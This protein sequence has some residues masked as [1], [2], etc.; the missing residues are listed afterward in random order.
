M[1]HFV[2]CA[3]FGGT[4]LPFTVPIIETGL[5]V[6]DLATHIRDIFTI[7]QHTDVILCDPEEGR[8]YK[9]RF[10]VNPGAGVQIQLKY[11][12]QSFPTAA[13]S[14]VST[15][16]V[17]ECNKKTVHVAVEALVFP[18]KKAAVAAAMLKPHFMTIDSEIY[19]KEFVGVGSTREC[20][21]LAVNEALEF[22]Q[23][24]R[25]DVNVCVCGALPYLYSKANLL[26][27]K[28][29]TLKWTSM[30]DPVSISLRRH[31]VKTLDVV[32]T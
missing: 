10:W 16:T 21:L 8:P 5:M 30:T 15:V 31:L 24:E 6:R 1:S 25:G 22:A 28:S 2:E 27:N 19:V 7:P 11:N 3:F 4:K 13:P 9:G 32:P 23:S 17:P 14:T 26:L 12:G 18:G 29:I 20:E